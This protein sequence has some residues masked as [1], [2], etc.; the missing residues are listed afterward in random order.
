MAARRDLRGARELRE[1][2]E[3]AKAERDYRTFRRAI[4]RLPGGEKLA[5][6][7]ERTFSIVKEWDKRLESHRKPP[8]INALPEPRIARGQKPKRPP[9]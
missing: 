5:A 7:A 8:Y 4:F 3:A 6:D 9:G 1:R 2:Q